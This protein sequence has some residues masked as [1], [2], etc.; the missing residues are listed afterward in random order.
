MM[1]PPGMSI[2][3]VI[4]IRAVMARERPQPRQ[5][6]PNPCRRGQGQLDSPKITNPVCKVAAPAMTSPVV[7]FAR[8]GVKIGVNRLFF[9]CKT[10]GETCV[11]CS[12]RSHLRPSSFNTERQLFNIN[13]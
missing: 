5:G 7:R 2:L 12:M 6:I 10:M 1:L 11:F 9:S 13:I 3:P 8:K 4:A